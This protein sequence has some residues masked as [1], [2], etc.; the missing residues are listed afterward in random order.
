MR[1]KSIIIVSI[2]VVIVVIVIAIGLDIVKADVVKAD[3]VKA[4][5]VE[6]QVMVNRQ[7]VVMADHVDGWEKTVVVTNM[8]VVRPAAEV[9]FDPVMQVVDATFP[10]GV[11]VGLNQEMGFV[12][13]AR[14]RVSRFV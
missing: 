2:L 6:N 14:G 11:E 10:D 3:V 4:D 5:A 9:V 1:R 13:V 7:V 12:G 8:G